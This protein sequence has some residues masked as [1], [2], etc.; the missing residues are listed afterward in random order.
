MSG[1]RL[2]EVRPSH[3]EG[4]RGLFRL[5]LDEES[6]P[7]QLARLRATAGQLDDLV[8]RGALL[9]TVREI[10]GELQLNALPAR[11]LEVACNAWLALRENG[12][13]S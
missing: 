4:V 11:D 3:L 10:V 1:G 12:G 6:D 9:V 8:E 7:K 5:A 13:D 2:R